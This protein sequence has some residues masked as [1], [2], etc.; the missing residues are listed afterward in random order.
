MKNNYRYQY[1]PNVVNHK[2]DLIQPKHSSNPLWGL[3]RRSITIAR[4]RNYLKRISLGDDEAIFLKDRHA[5][6]DI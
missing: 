1:P 5:T 3:K 6:A 4:S 2:I